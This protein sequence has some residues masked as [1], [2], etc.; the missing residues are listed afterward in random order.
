MERRRRLGAQ[1]RKEIQVQD[2]LVWSFFSLLLFL[3]DLSVAREKEH[4]LLRPTQSLTHIRLLGI[5]M[6][7]GNEQDE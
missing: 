5:Y 7:K 6:Y 2:T 1:K 3:V 4:L